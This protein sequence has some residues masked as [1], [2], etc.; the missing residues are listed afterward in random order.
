MND[1]AAGTLVRSAIPTL[2]A[3]AVRSIVSHAGVD[4]VPEDLRYCPTAPYP[5][6]PT[7]PL[8]SV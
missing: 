8:A 1:D 2:V 3:V 5:N 6:S 7:S 4:A